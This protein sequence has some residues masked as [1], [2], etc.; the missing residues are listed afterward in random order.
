[1]KP[2]QAEF[3]K[4]K[5]WKD[6][7]EA[8]ARSKGGLCEKCLKEGRYTPGE[9]VHHKIHLDPVKFLDPSIS[10]CWDNLELLC[11]KHHA[12]EHGST[13]RYKVDEAG[14]VTIL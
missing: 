9:I 11:R 6:C 1:M 2:W 4:S 12:E 5:A 8:Y 3:Y 13:K 10:L 14:R 7:R